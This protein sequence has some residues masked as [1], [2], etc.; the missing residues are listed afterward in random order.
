MRMFAIPTPT[1][2]AP[3]ANR[4]AMALALAGPAVVV[5]LCGG[6]AGWLPAA[7]PD[8][9]Q[10]TNAS[11]SR[12]PEAVTVENFPRAESHRY[13]A[14]VVKKGEL[15]RFEHNRAPTPIDQQTV[16]R[17]NRDTLYSG[18]VFDLNAGPVTI[19]LP[20][21]GKR[22][23]SLQVIDEDHYTPAVVYGP[24]IFTY[25]RRQVGTRYAM[26]VVRTLFDPTNPNDLAEVHKLQDAVRTEHTGRGTFEI[27]NW[28]PVSQKKVRDALLVLGTTLPA[29]H[30]MFG[31]RHD[32][33][34]VAHLIGSALGWGGNPAKDAIYHHVTPPQNDGK[35]VYRLNLNKVPVDA[36]WSLS[37]YNAQ[38]Y[39]EPNPE[40]A[41]SVN[42]LTAR[43]NPDGSITV[44][45]G[46]RKGTSP[47]SNWLPTMPG[48]NY[49]LRLY[50]PRKEVL[51]GTWKFPE[52]EIVP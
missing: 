24:G 13:F 36:F 4:V 26:M 52:A 49:N 27:P 5:V 28:D 48:W 50:R 18:A 33:D 40:D 23:M 45:L 3:R 38:G 37:I 35:T 32:V 1:V 22:F 34:P 15:G 51:D 47:T 25:S 10:K 30:R 12:P 9:D 44:Q 29:S 6:L 11:A 43:P 16:I 2:N 41:Y 42:N 8:A 14:A 21:P 20:D 19:T 17:M 7:E 39:F 31:A 46:G